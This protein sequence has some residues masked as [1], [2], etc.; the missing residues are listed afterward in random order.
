MRVLSKFFPKSAVSPCKN[1]GQPPETKMC[2]I[3]KH[4]CDRS[5]QFPQSP[6]ADVSDRLREAK[7]PPWRPDGVV[8]GG[9]LF[10]CRSFLSFF[11]SFAKGSP[12]WLYRQGTCLAQMVGYGCNFKNWVQNLG[13]DPPLKFGGPHVARRGTRYCELPLQMPH[14]GRQVVAGRARGGGASDHHTC[15]GRDTSNPR[16]QQRLSSMSV[17]V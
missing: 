6:L 7:R 2:I 5:Q 3:E 4:L 13:G 14:V 9:I 10:Y 16:L 11:F 12:R 8:A 15:P 17:V 1:W